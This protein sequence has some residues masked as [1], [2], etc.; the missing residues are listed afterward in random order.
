MEQPNQGFSTYVLLQG[1]QLAVLSISVLE[2]QIPGPKSPLLN[3]TVAENL[4]TVI[5]EIFMYFVEFF[6]ISVVN[7]TAEVSHPMYTAFGVH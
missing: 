3:P 2:G 4:L 5:T 7:I 1:P 6:Y